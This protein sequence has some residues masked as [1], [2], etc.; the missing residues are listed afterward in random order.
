[1]SGDGAAGTLD[2]SNQLL[3]ESNLPLVPCYVTELKQ[4]FLSLL[5]HACHSRITS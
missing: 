2:K 3:L 4:V 1:M 5:R